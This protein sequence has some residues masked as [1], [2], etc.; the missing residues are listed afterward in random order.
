MNYLYY[1]L[2]IILFS[3]I[4]ILSQEK[5]SLLYE[6]SPISVTSEELTI[7]GTLTMPKN[8]RQPIPLALIIAG[9]GATDRNGNNLNA[10]LNTN[11]Y[12]KLAFSLAI[13]G[14]ASV[15][16]DKRNVGES[17]IIKVNVE[18]RIFN[19]EVNDTKRIIDMLNNDHRFSS[20]VIIGHSQGSLV[21]ILS[22]GNEIDKFISIAGVGKSGGETLKD[23]LSKQPEYV[24]Q[25][26]NPIIDSLLGGFYVKDVP[27]FL[28]P[29]FKPSIQPYLIS[30]FKYD[31]AVEL[32][33]LNIPSLV[34]QGTNDLQIGVVDAERLVSQTDKVRL[35][36]IKNMNHM[37]KIIDGTIEDNQ[38]SYFN[39]TIPISE[40]L[41]KVIVDFIIDS[42]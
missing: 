30:W 19:A 41:V 21:G 10:G 31:P 14:I 28:E 34:I 12:Q 3:P 22:V 37:L 26:A 5:D 17:K 4:N 6:E 24:S 32:A 1:I 20:I 42:K 25:K 16:Y 13:K 38:N 40:E 11:A 9:S 18:N 36:T 8:Y 35:V 29:L 33:K 23:Q 7:Y 39:P 2:I 15:R 27:D